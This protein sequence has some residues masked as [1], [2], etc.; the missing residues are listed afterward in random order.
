MPIGIKYKVH[1]LRV[2]KSIPVVI[3]IIAFNFGE[4]KEKINNS[5]E[6]CEIPNML[7]I[8]ASSPMYLTHM[9]SQLFCMAME[10]FILTSPY[11]ARE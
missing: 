10:K 7:N 11:T 2:Y 8:S 3:I 6:L 5:I 4:E 9:H 1:N